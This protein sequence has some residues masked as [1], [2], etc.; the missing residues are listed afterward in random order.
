MLIAARDKGAAGVARRRRISS[1][2][3]GMALLAVGLLINL[4]IM[5]LGVMPRP[6]CHPGADR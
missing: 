1:L 5:P 2:I 4:V 3:L 6:Y